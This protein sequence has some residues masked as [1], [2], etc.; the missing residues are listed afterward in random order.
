MRND[1]RTGTRW[2]KVLDCVDPTDVIVGDQKLTLEGTEA[3]RRYSWSF[4]I[5]ARVRDLRD[6]SIPVNPKDA[7]VMARYEH[8]VS[9]I[10]HFVERNPGVVPYGAP[11]L[12][13]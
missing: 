10:A 11:D 5:V 6:S 13:K 1:V 4:S 7:A 3:S 2:K 8:V 9:K 12:R